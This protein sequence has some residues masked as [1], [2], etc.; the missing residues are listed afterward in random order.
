MAGSA[1]IPYHSRHAAMDAACTH[2]LTALYP[3]LASL[4]A[5]ERDAVLAHE[6]QHITVPAA[7]VLFQEGAP[8]RGFP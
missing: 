4:D 3:P 5:A 8:C 7:A 2:R 6:A 1:R